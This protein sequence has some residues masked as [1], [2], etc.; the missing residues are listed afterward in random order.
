MS[1]PS[2]SLVVCDTTRRNKIN[3]ALEKT[4]E[5][6]NQLSDFNGISCVHWICDQPPDFELSVPFRYTKI[7][8][9]TQF[10]LEYNWVM[11]RLVPHIVTEDYC[12][13]IHADGFA[14]NPDAWTAE[15]LEY[16]YI[17]ATWPWLNLV[18]NG[19]F[20]LRSRKLQDAM[21]DT[22]FDYNTNEDVSICQEN[23]S[24]LENTYGIK[25]APIE[26][27]DQFSIE[28]KTDSPW[29]GKSFGFHG[30]GDRVAAAYGY[31]DLTTGY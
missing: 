31:P 25:F 2:L 15:F 3:P 7:K 29:L 26:L 21:I 14:C 11:L 17:G 22:L 1:K 18:G 28:F 19:G 23:R 24:L 6:V 20:S 30:L 9:I 4:I 13:T 8:Q 5:T 16:D 12:L 27:A 10:P